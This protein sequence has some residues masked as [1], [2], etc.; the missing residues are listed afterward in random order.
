MKQF[1]GMTELEV[2]DIVKRF[3]QAHF[4]KVISTLEEYEAKWSL[5]NIQI[6]SNLTANLIFT[7]HSDQF[8]DAVLKIGYPASPEIVT[9]VNA[10]KEYNGGKFCRVYESDIKA[11]I[12]LEQYIAPGITLRAESSLDAR[13]AV[14]C[15]LY[16]DLH[17]CSKIE[18]VYPTYKQWVYRITEYMR[19]RQDCTDLYLKMKK[20]KAVFD[21]VSLN[22]NGEYLLHGDLH[23]D[24][25]LLN[26]DGAYAII[27]PKGV[28]GDPVF[29]IPRFILNE[30]GNEVT[31][32]LQSKVSYIITIL[33]EQLHIPSHVLKLCLYVEIT[34]A[35]C[36]C[37][38]SGSDSSELAKLMEKIE[39]T[40]LIMES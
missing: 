7:C 11:G 24:N 32:A 27:D 36:W 8:G 4:D 17:I 30:F 6:K 31:P 10:L 28:I 39:L 20:A 2:R 34:M 13:L 37:A 21:N 18:G 9:E 35:V 23:H 22:Y 29:D 5:T 40:E 12:F 33:A 3:G 1:Y 16:Q 19:N 25:I 26:Q 15:G 38:E 14:F